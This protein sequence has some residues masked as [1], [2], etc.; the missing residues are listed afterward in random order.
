MEIAAYDRDED[1]L[2]GTRRDGQPRLRVYRYP[3]PAVVLGSGSRPE[4]ELHLEPCIED[5]VPLLRR[6]GGGCSVVL[7]PGNLVTSVAMA[8]EGIGDNLR[9]FR[10]LG[11]WLIGGLERLGL[12]GVRQDGISDLVLADR[13]VGGACIYRSRGL[14]F[15]SATLLVDPDLE[16]IERYLKHPPREPDYRRGRPH[17][18]FVGRLAVADGEELGRALEQ[19]LER[20]LSAGG[21]M[22]SCFICGD[23][24]SF[25]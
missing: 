22:I 10:S 6:R 9:H 23:R 21:S 13:K 24:S 3:E 7:D 15:Y 20:A 11:A 14:L 12:Q 2:E 4:Q 17:R 18:D 16:R 8:V 19:Q 5:R 25:G 1:L